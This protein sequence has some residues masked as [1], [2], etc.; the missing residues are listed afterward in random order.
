MSSLGEK[1]KEVFTGHHH[2]DTKHA[3][4]SSNHNTHEHSKLT[5]EPPVDFSSHNT[6]TVPPTVTQQ[7][8]ALTPDPQPQPLN[9]WVITPILRH[10]QSMPPALLASIPTGVICQGTMSETTILIAQRMVCKTAR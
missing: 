9:N 2:D 7:S 1:I 3:D 10:R 8:A 5:K 6:T 4:E